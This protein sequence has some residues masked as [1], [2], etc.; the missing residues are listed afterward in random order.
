[1]RFQHPLDKYQSK[2]GRV[3]WEKKSI[4][5]GNVAETFAVWS[6]VVAQTA[7]EWC[8][9][10]VGYLENGRLKEQFACTRFCCKL[11]NVT[12]TSEMLLVAF[13]EQALPGT[14]VFYWFPKFSS[15]R[16]CF[17]LRMSI[18]EKSIKCGLSR[19]TC[20]QKQENHSPW[21]Y[22]HVGNFNW[23]SSEHFEEL[24]IR[25]IV[26]KFA[27]HLL[28]EKQ[29]DHISAFHD[30][31]RDLNK[32]LNSCW[33]WVVSCGFACMT[34]RPDTVS[35]PWTAH[36]HSPPQKEGWTHLLKCEA[37]ANVFQYSQIRALWICS[38]RTACKPTWNWPDKC[39]LRN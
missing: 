32:T 26:A 9:A 19:L 28:S 35:L 21:S 30:F 31:Q 23:V 15:G 2:D 8:L 38:T 3:H 6:K 39:N 14:Q 33:A 27:H 5:H 36:H 12:G 13:G 34:H 18:N 24:R 17:T 1:M 20:P 29:K 11:V 4:L 37:Y 7:V 10:I 25:H 22:S 16:R